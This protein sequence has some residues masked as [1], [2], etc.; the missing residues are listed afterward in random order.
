MG[1]HDFAVYTFETRVTHCVFRLLPIHLKLES[2]WL[3]VGVG[4]DE[5]Y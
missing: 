1:K 3:P 4:Q 2:R 5:K